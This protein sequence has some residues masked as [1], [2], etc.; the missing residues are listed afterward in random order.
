MNKT[1]VGVVAIAVLAGAVF[2]GKGIFTSDG[3]TDGLMANG[4]KAT[5]ARTV[6]TETGGVPHHEPIQ[7]RKKDA[8]PAI[9]K[10]EF[11]PG[12]VS[13]IAGGTKGIGVEING[14]ARFYP[15]Y[16]LQYHQVVNDTVGDCAIAC[17]Y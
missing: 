16:V 10:P 11:I 4:Q 12:S 5:H 8:R 15:L 17:S 13:K 9:V 2:F 6:E 3:P 1:V 7:Y 14:E